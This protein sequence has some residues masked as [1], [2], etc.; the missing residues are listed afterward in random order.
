M[1]PAALVYNLGR[2]T[3]TFCPELKVVLISGNQNERRQKLEDSQDADV[4]VTS[5]DLLKRDIDQYDALKFDFQ[6]PG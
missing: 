6:D 1:A 4:L 3:G 2:R 5:Y